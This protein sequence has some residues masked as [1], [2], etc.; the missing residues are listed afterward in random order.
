MGTCFTECPNNC[1]DENHH[2]ITGNGIRPRNTA[3][4]FEVSQLEGVEGGLD[5]RAFRPLS[6]LTMVLRGRGGSYEEEAEDRSVAL[7]PLP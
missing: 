4:R 5:L 1:L 7:T 3:L 2:V 6:P